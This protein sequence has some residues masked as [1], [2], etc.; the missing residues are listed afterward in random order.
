M[1]AICACE[2]ATAQNTSK[3]DA[4]RQAIKYDA[5]S[6]EV[7][8]KAKQTVLKDIVISQG[9]RQVRADR[10]RANSL[11]FDNSRW[12]FEGN[13]RINAESGGNLRSDQAVVEFRDKHIAK[14]TVTGKP[15]EFE[16]KRAETDQ[17]AH[18][19]ADEIVYD[20]KDGTVRLMGNAWLSNG[21]NEISG[22]LLVYN[23]RDQKLQAAT[24]PGT[25]QRV[26]IT[27]EPRSGEPGKPDSNKAE[28]NKSD[29]TKA[30]PGKPEP[31]KPEPKQP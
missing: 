28:P 14:A 9:I 5:A 12:N 19:H 4:N 29:S 18:G 22:P 2:V 15:A 30:E 27:I 1:L 25:D 16:Q 8:Y 13:V 23:I 21:Q 24:P 7:D 3:Q 20:V 26:R 11:D 31:N 17:V 6:L 10:A